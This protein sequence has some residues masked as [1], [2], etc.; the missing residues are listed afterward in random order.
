MGLF[1]WLQANWW[2]VW[3]LLAGGLAVSELLTLDLTLLMLAAGALAGGVTA[4][5]LP[6]LIWVQVLVA[7]VVAVLMLGVLRPPMLKRLHKGPGYVSSVGK[8][9]GSSG[10]AVGGFPA[11]D[12]NELHV[13]PEDDRAIEAVAAE[14]DA[15][16]DHAHLLFYIWLPD[17]SGVRVAE[18]CIRAARRGVA[19]DA[20]GR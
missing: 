16:R 12:G 4:L 14:I 9:V 10:R 7:V 18:A 1:D 6:G 20:P 3:L 13:L 19:G 5:F 11:V 8:L 15:A 2:A 17:R